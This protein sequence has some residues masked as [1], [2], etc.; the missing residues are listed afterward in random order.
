MMD[1]SMDFVYSGPILRFCERTIAA[2]RCLA[3]EFNQIVWQFWLRLIQICLEL[4][5]VVT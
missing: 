4:L 1:E 2:V 5:G 3:I